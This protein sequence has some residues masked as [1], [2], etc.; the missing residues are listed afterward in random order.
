MPLL[1]NPSATVFDCR[2]RRRPM[3]F[4]DFLAATESPN[5]RDVAM[6]W[7][8]ARGAK[9]MPAW[10]DIDPTAIAPHLPIVW[11]WRYDRDTDTFTGRLA[12]DAIVEAFGRSP[13][14][15]R[16]QD[17]FGEKW[18]AQFFAKHKR[19]VSEP[20]FTYERGQVLIHAQRYG[21]GERIIM[22]LATDGLHADGIFGATE[23][24]MSPNTPPRSESA[25][26]FLAADRLVYFAL[27]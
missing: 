1:G 25:R 7:N 12:G 21:D 16:M 9:R 27:E 11:S 15:V 23:Y 6:H 10:R 20:A 22:P 4:E 14:G 8:V 24:A 18:Y 17:F 13:R 26:R 19:I 2:I 3:S 5:L